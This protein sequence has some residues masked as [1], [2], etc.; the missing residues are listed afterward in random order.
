MSEDLIPIVNDRL[1]AGWREHLPECLNPNDEAEV[2]LDGHDPNLLRIHIVTEGRSGYTFD[3]TVRYLDDREIEV[4]FVD[5]DQEGRTADER[6][7]KI[8]ALIEDYVRHL[9]ECAQILQ[10]VTHA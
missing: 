6:T 3:F 1:I 10:R 2:Q 8:Q 9:H 4:G 7:D 5:V